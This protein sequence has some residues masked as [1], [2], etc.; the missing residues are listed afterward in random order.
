MQ[1]TTLSIKLENII[2]EDNIANIIDDKIVV[3]GGIYVLLSVFSAI[4]SLFFGLLSLGHAL[5]QNGS[6]SAVLPL[7]FLSMLS[8]VGSVILAVKAKKK[9]VSWGVAILGIVI[10]VLAVLFLFPIFFP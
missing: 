10:S 9:G 5:S 3:G 8:V 7:F 6:G 2:T 4:G 1:S